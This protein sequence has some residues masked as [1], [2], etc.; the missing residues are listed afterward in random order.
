MTL[1]A[2]FHGEFEVGGMITKGRRR[3][4]ILILE[5]STMCGRMVICAVCVVS[6]WFQT[7]R[8]PIEH[9]APW[10][11]PSCAICVLGSHSHPP[12]FHAYSSLL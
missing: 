8:R 11:V 3:M 2:E 5:F 10:C 7:D 4:F 12:I 6:E 1:A 9:D